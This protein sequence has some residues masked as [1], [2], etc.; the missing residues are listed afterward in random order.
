VA[1]TRRFAG[2]LSF[3]K[4][5]SLDSRKTG[6]PD[7]MKMRTSGRWSRCVAN[8][9]RKG[10]SST[11]VGQPRCTAT[12]VATKSNLM[13]A[14]RNYACEKTDLDL[15]REKSV[16]VSIRRKGTQLRNER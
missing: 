7:K 14:W 12:F 4:F 15:K 11:F 2:S 3:S 10:D 8:L 6:A 9:R 13:A 1:P 16:L 5:A